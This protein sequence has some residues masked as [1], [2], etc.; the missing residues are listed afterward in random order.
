LRECLYSNTGVNSSSHSACFTLFYSVC[1][2]TERA[3]WKLQHICF[4]STRSLQ[5]SWR[6]A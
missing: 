2:R 3:D 4:H 1:S 6:I 5:L